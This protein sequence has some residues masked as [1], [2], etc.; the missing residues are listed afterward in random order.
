MSPTGAQHGLVEV[1]VVN[2]LQRFVRPK[3]LG[4]V[5]SGE[6]GVYTRR[7]PDTVRAADVLFVSRARLP[8]L[9][10]RGFLE[11]AP[12]LVVEI[13]SPSES[14][15]ELQQKIREYRAIGVNWVWVVEPET[16]RVWVYRQEGAPQ[17]LSESDTL[18]GEGILTGLELQVAQLFES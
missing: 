5:L 7:N 10:T 3:Q 13:V 17:E 16:R 11:V 9:P 12:E 18:V 1:N 4:W 14:Q 2:A 8:E 15:K 6:V